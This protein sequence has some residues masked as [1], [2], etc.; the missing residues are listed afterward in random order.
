MLISRLL[1]VLAL[2]AL[3]GAA[4]AEPP[5]RRVPDA[6]A[7]RQTL[8]L[9]PTSA[10]SLVAMPNPKM[11]ADDLAECLASLGEGE[12]ALPMRPIDLFKSRLGLGG[13]IDEAGMFAMWFQMRDGKAVP[14]ML[15]PVTGAQEFLDANFE[16]V[17][18]P[19]GPAY[20][21]PEL[22]TLHARAL[23]RRV[24]LSTDRTLVDGYAQSA[25]MTDALRKR[26]GDRGFEVLTAGDLAAWGGPEATADARQQAQA[27]RGA[28]RRAAAGDPASASAARR[29]RRGSA[30]NAPAS[31]ELRGD[32]DGSGEVDSGD[33]GA[34][35]LEMG[36]KGGRADLDGDGTVTQADV[37]Q[38]QQMLEA[39]PAVGGSGT[40]PQG[41]SGSAAAPEEDADAGI[42]AE[43]DPSEGLTEGAFSLDF[44]PLGA[45]SR[46][47]A[48]LDP[49]TPL[50][51]ATRGGAAGAA[52]GLRHLPQGPFVLA[53]SLDPSGLGGVEAV[54]ELRTLAPNA[55]AIPEWVMQN[56][57][58]IS[59]VEFAIYPSKLGVAGGG[60][61]NE[62]CLWLG[63]ADS[64]KA[65]ELLKSWMTGLS[66]TREGMETK[67]VWEEGKTTK[68][69][70]VADAWSVVEQP[71]PGGKARPNPSRR[72]MQS[73]VFG[74][75]GATGFVK[76]F[77]DGLL[78][79]FSQRPDVLKR[80]IEAAEG[81]KA[82]EASPTITALRGWLL[83]K[84]DVEAYLGVGSLLAV[85]RQAVASLPG[86]GFELPDAP[87]GL[88]PV[89]FAMQV[90]DARVETATM[91]PSGVIGVMAELYRIRAQPPEGDA[92]AGD[93]READ[94]P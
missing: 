66:G 24:L 92:P 6:A 54:A 35:L 2:S 9:I 33:M 22:G 73:M 31:Q 18:T 67:V 12:A 82:L 56:R 63:T 91:V 41:R 38:L 20:R 4:P 77:P 69:G 59:Q 26:L 16:K 72:L 84:P 10:I 7:W 71:A 21:H 75:R 36:K 28:P 23:E 5:V 64:S 37:K 70:L 15:V 86:G 55:P 76:T 60:L 65:H 53:A 93:E 52:P 34:L 58:L 74:P 79:T 13:G 1:P 94:K 17:Q 42:P 40:S 44:D 87:P 48:I 50:G 14:A 88:E 29:Q 11:A 57:D 83:P 8:D 68:D 51:R 30:G 46:T 49:A 43:P 80:C 90:Q 19:E 3:W 32:L 47:Y 81:G 39:G 85:A 25:G 27:M 45:S 89:A 78:V 62:A 61:L